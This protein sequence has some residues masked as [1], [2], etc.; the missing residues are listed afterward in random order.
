V[1]QQRLR[2]GVWGGLHEAAET[3]DVGDD[4]AHAPNARLAQRA[5]ALL[6]DELRQAGHLA[7]VHMAQ[8]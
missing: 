4:H 2:H 7:A 1:Q 6:P 5:L 8:L 3:L